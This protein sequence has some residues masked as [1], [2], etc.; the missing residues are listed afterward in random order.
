MHSFFCLYL[1]INAPDFQLISLDRNTIIEH[2]V[3]LRY[4]YMLWQYQKLHLKIWGQSAWNWQKYDDLSNTISI[5]P[6]S[7][8]YCRMLFAYFYWFNQGIDLH[9]YKRFKNAIKCMFLFIRVMKQKT[10]FL[11]ITH[12][13][14]TSTESLRLLSPAAYPPWLA[15]IG[16]VVVSVSKSG[17]GWLF[18][19]HLFSFTISF[20][21]FPQ[22]NAQWFRVKIIIM[23]QG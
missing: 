13:I 18:F 15:S 5:N 23:Q 12:S 19:L 16:P 8:L 3:N 14:V 10:C 4:R 2:I 1:T 9:C 11:T 22:T 17:H 6:T 7:K 21:S 20:S